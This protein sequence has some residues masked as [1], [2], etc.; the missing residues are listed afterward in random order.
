VDRFLDSIFEKGLIKG[1]RHHVH[2]SADTATAMK[3]G[4][5]RGRPVL[6]EV[7]AARL[8]ADGAKVYVSDNGVW[9]I[10]HVPPGYLRLAA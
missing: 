8:H 6:L 5:R 9:L 1:N 4:E 7:Y 3:V 10:E 2:L